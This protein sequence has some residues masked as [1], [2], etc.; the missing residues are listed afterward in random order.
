MLTPAD[1]PLWLTPSPVTSNHQAGIHTAKAHIK[2]GCFNV[3]LMLG[4]FINLCLIDVYGSQT[5]TSVLC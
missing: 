5:I 2:S 1:Q 3:S 4:R